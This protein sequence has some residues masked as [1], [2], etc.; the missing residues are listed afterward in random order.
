[1][2][3]HVAERLQLSAKQRI[4]ISQQ[5]TDRDRAQNPEIAMLV[6]LPLP[7]RHRCA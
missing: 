1:M 6:D 5:H 7:A 3:Q 2:D 4:E